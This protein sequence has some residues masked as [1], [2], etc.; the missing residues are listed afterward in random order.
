MTAL[1]VVAAALGASVLATARRRAAIALVAALAAGAAL[2][3]YHIGLPSL[4]IDEFI[5]AWVA[6]APTLTAAWQRAWQAVPGMP[7]YYA[8][9]WL[10]RHVLG[11]DEV[12]LRLP[13][14][15][16]GLAALP[17]AYGLGREV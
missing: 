10:S 8:G 15:V 17:L 16:A 3:L 14:V 9:A 12:A 13:S 6:R 1:V 4:W 2:R 11:E 5:T 7:I